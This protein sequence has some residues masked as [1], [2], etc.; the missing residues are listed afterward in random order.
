[1]SNKYNFNEW[2]DR[3]MP[4][5]EDNGVL[6]KY[7]YT[8]NGKSKVIFYLSMILLWSLSIMASLYM[9][10][11]GYFKDNINQQ[12]S[13]EPQVNVTSFYDFKPE[14]NNDYDFTPKNNFTIYNN[15]ILDG[16]SICEVF[17]S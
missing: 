1:M 2:V 5:L 15:I 10:Y 13:L 4:I 16:E 11:N 14:T 9:G 7:G 6:K 17:C 12:V 8:R 3:T